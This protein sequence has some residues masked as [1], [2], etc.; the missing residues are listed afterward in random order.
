MTTTTLVRIP[1]ESN[2]M[3]SLSNLHLKLVRVI[4][5]QVLRSFCSETF[6]YLFVDGGVLR[7]FT[8]VLR[9]HLCVNYLFE[10]VMA[11]KV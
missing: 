9:N 3:D 6:D 8:H 11:F 4:L 5:T 10:I 1:R 2:D 7:S